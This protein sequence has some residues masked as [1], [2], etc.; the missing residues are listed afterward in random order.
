MQPQFQHRHCR[1]AIFNKR[2]SLFIRVTKAEATAEPKP[3]GEAVLSAQRSEEEREN[4]GFFILPGQE[5]AI[6]GVD[7]QCAAAGNEEVVRGT[8]TE[9]E[10]DARPERRLAP[11]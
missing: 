3:L 6:F 7:K 10:E 9:F 1:A 4:T 11:N 2:R 5:V 8:R